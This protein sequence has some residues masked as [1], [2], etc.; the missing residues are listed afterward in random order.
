VLI[1]VLILLLLALTGTLWFV[2][3]VAVGVAIGLI[4]ATVALSAL[5]VW[6]VRRAL[7]WDRNRQ[8]WRRVPRSR[9]EVL[10]PPRDEPPS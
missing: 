6:R 10:H 9:V 3:K 5:L 1:F 8:R 4:L 2:V 7:G